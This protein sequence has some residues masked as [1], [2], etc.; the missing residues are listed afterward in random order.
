MGCGGVVGV[1]GGW[2]EGEVRLP[3]RHWPIC[4]HEYPDRSLFLIVGIDAFLS[5]PK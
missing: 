1:V 2:G 3:P 4:V 5:L